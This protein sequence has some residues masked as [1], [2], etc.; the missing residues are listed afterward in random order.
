MEGDLRKRTRK[1]SIEYTVGF[2]ESLMTVSKKFLS[3][4]S[5]LSLLLI[6]NTFF[7]ILKGCSYIGKWVYCLS[8][9]YNKTL[10]LIEFLSI[11]E[12]KLKKY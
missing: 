5:I 10:F 7:T 6:A 4:L 12:K 9:R 8:L 1:R 2:Q 3:I 11:L